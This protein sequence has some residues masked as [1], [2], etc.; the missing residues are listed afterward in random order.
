M[1]IKFSSKE[2]ITI[3]FILAWTLAL[4]IRKLPSLNL[5]IPFKFESDLFVYFLSPLVLYFFTFYYL[6]LFIKTFKIK[7]IVNFIKFS[8][9]L[10]LAIFYDKIVSFL[11]T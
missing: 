7:P 11:L 10:I 8:I 2:E 3:C 6:I 5:V 4:L 1:K 9:F